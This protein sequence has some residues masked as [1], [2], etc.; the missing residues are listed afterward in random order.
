MNDDKRKR[1]RALELKSLQIA[2]R[3]LLGD[4][5]LAA[6][7]LSPAELEI[8]RRERFM[9]G[10]DNLVSERHQDL[11]AMLAA[12][13][14]RRASE[15]ITEMLEARIEEEAT[16]RQWPLSGSAPARVIPFRA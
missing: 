6:E 9:L 15:L 2:G 16:T 5:R 10:I 3:P 13:E 4:E 12:L 11:L 8:Y 1:P 7:Y 14:G